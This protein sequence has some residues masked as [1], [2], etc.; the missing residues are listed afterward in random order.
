MLL[1]NS[2]FEVCFWRFKIRV[3]HGGV[4]DR[5]SLLGC[6]AVLLG[7]YFWIFWIVTVRA[8]SESDSPIRKGC[9]TVKMK[10]LW[11]F[12]MTGTTDWHNTAW[13]IS[14][15]TEEVLKSRSVTECYQAFATSRVSLQLVLLFLS[16]VL[17][18]LLTGAQTMS[19]ATWV[20]GSSFQPCI[21]G[22]F[23]L[24]IILLIN[25][26]CQSWCLNLLLV[27]C[28]APDIFVVIISVLCDSA[29]ALGSWTECELEK[30]VCS[31]NTIHAVGHI[32][33]P[34][35]PSV[36]LCLYIMFKIMSARENHQPDICCQCERTVLVEADNLFRWGFWDE[37]AD[38]GWVTARHVHLNYYCMF[39]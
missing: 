10:A 22:E 20:R 31:D 30:W 3:S 5:S 26:C 19:S 1:L 29:A 34:V 38:C 2:G 35:V 13:I 4:A 36:T 27:L 25:L 39:Q 7:R 32:S 8:L 16:D 37:D 15:S 6:D 33:T 21:L 18:S 9:L 11:P 23:S 17:C 14:C 28:A 24:C 12:E